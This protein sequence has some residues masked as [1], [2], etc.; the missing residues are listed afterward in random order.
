MIYLCI[1]ILCVNVHLYVLLTHLKHAELKTVITEIYLELLR[2]PQ[3]HQSM[4]ELLCENV[5]LVEA[6]AQ[7]E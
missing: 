2:A 7:K 6:L 4:D 5:R 3:S 1:Y